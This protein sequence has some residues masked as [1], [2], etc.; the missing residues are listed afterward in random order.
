MV[1]NGPHGSYP[2]LPRLASYIPPQALPRSMIT[3]SGHNEVPIQLR[4]G[5]MKLY[6][7]LPSEYVACP[8]SNDAAYFSAGQE[9]VKVLFT[10]LCNLIQHLVVIILLKQDCYQCFRRHRLSA[11]ESVPAHPVEDSCKSAHLCGDRVRTHRF[12]ECSGLANVIVSE[13]PRVLVVLDVVYPEYG[14]GFLADGTT[15][16]EEVVI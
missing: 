4:Q 5:P 10:V 12:G 11:P 1:P 9:S 3:L 8:L 16:G 14:R 2:T 6:A 13:V 15:D 7:L